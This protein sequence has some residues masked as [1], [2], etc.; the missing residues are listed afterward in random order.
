MVDDDT[1]HAETWIGRCS[2]LDSGRP[3][4]RTKEEL[5]GEKR[6]RQRDVERERGG[7]KALYHVSIHS[8]CPLPPTSPPQ[9][10]K[11]EAREE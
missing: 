8:M 9:R 4:L 11:D 5:S 7:I 2:A 10:W 3:A 6:E 1:V